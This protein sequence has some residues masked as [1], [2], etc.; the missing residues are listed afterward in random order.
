MPTSVLLVEDS[1]AVRKAT[2]CYLEI[3]GFEICGEV[4]DGLDAIEIAPKLKPD[5]IVLDL[6]MPRM[7]GFAAARTLH[8]IMPKT[9]LVIFTL[10][11]EILNRPEAP[12]V[13]VQAAVSK[14]DGLNALA[15]EITS[16]VRA[17]SHC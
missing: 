5:C 13:G 4:S 1:E 9:P 10:Y 15:A 17:D 14:T 6:A 12:D 16:L 7:N 11:K 3:A 2:R 8:Q